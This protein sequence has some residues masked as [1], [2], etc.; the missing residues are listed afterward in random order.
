DA[1]GQIDIHD[2]K[3]VKFGGLWSAYN[4]LM[5]TMS[6]S[7]LS[8]SFINKVVH[9]ADRAHY[10]SVIDKENLISS[11]KNNIPKLGCEFRRIVEQNKMVWMRLTVNVFPDPITD[12]L[13]AV[14]YIKN[15]DKEKKNELMLQRESRRDSLTGC[16]NR[17]MTETS[18]REY[19]SGTRS[20]AYAFIILDLDDF[21]DINDTYGHSTG[22]KVLVTFASVLKKQ[23]KKDDIIGRFGGDEFIAFI[24]DISS[25]EPEKYIANILANIIK[26][27]SDSLEISVSCSIGAVIGP[28]YASSYEKLFQ[29]ADSALYSSKNKGKST[30]TLY[31]GS[32]TSSSETGMV[33]PDKPIRSGNPVQYLFEDEVENGALVCDFA[34][35][36]GEH[37]DMAYIVDI[38]TFELIK[39]N[40][41][42]YDR[43]GVSEEDWIGVKCYELLHERNTPCPFCSKL[44]WSDEKF[45]IWKNYNQI[46]EQD[47]LIKNKLIN[48]KGQTVMLAIAVDIS[49]NKN[50]TDFV[51]YSINSEKMLIN[52]IYKITEATSIEE[53]ISISLEAIAHFYKADRVQLWEKG[54]PNGEYV[55]SNEYCLDEK[56]SFPTSYERT[57]AS[58]LDENHGNLYAENPDDM[59]IHSFDMYKQMKS[60]SINNYRVAQIISNGDIFGCIVIENVR[61]YHKY[62]S[63]I[64]SLRYFIVKEIQRYMREGKFEYMRRHD[65]LTGL[66]NRVSYEEYTGSFNAER[67]SSVGV[68]AAN[69]NELN[70]INNSLGY[71][72]G[73]AVIKEISTMLK[74]IFNNA[75]I[76]RPS[77]DEFIVAAENISKD[78]F[79]ENAAILKNA[80]NCSD[81][82]SVA[83]GYVWDN[84]EKNLGLLIWHSYEIMKINKQL[85]HNRG[86]DSSSHPKYEMLNQLLSGLE[87]GDYIVYYQPKKDLIKNEIIG[88]EALIR[89]V[90][91]D[92][93]V[94]VPAEFLKKFEENGIIRYIDLFVFEEVCKLLERRQ[95][96]GCKPLKISVN[97]SKITLF[98]SEILTV[99][100]G[101]I[102]KYNIDK[103]F[104]EIEITESI[105]GMG[106]NILCRIA[107]DIKNSGFSLSLDDF[108]IKHSNLSS[109]AD[110]SFDVIKLDKSLI[111]SLIDNTSNRIILKNIINMCNELGSKVIA[112]GVETVEQE[113]ILAD[114]GCRFVQGYLYGKPMPVEEF[115][116]K[117]C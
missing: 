82:Y 111:H 81:K 17:K 114:L 66:L 4:N 80:L 37:G 5:N 21:K 67:I 99:I 14:L 113:Q 53:S 65:T 116:Q 87:K 106:K 11:Y 12:H 34:T 75:K 47:F 45:Y 107:Q 16:L 61:T 54:I 91:D 76:F 39:G 100:E 57:V 13:A 50:V 27:F 88:A 31:N 68:L 6:Y 1:W 95:N 74:K 96:D 55:L 43:V 92:G 105:S 18:I 8:T 109:L 117:Y 78:T 69:I 63:F 101:I 94:A 29:C 70:K 25:D 83:V 112:E 46:L 108:G 19:I 72:E 36:L 10:L 32:H 24:K 48:W 79:E 38:N 97:F 52:A 86:I 20:S 84:V 90:K 23:L 102:S 51:D 98:E 42:F 49:N 89:Q 110:V 93:K 60:M 22:D 44:N 71:N 103:K 28:K 40:K 26:S 33:K 62:T 104:I 3:I 30:F 115:K 56:M 9:P 59:L 41:A 15:I 2:D 58:F 85:Y 35:L 73:N 64:D 7:E 77:G